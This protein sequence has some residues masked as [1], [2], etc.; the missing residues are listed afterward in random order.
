[1]GRNF[2]ALQAIPAEAR[3]QPL[4]AAQRFRDRRQHKG[5]PIDLHE[6]A[7][8]P[9]KFAMTGLHHTPVLLHCTAAERFEL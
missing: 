6:S 5:L 8:T 7:F 2:I 1:M 9:G 4:R 3:T